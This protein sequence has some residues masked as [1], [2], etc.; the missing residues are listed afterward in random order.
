M[1]KA[2]TRMSR[3]LAVGGVAAIVF[4]VIALFWPGISLVALT[5]LF[6]AYAFVY[7]AFAL[8]AGL[9]LIAH[10]STEW[11]APT[12]GGIAGIV[13]A[14]ITFLHPGVTLL[15]LTYLVAAWAFVTGV[16]MIVWAIEFWGAVD[17]AVWIALS[18]VASVLF[19]ILVAVQPGSGLLAI[20]WVIGI[21]AVVAG[22][23]Q[24]V[25]SYRIHQMQTTVKRAF[26]ATAQPAS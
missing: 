1:D 14:A 7:G 21:Y 25:G 20:V 12:L 24:L 5:A 15:A 9:Q 11:V 4:G 6:G 23:L 16:A 2:F 19:G 3:Y 17:G 18:G 26:G 13:I 10:K 22:V 8:G